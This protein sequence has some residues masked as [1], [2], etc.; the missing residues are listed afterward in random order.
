MAKSRVKPAPEEQ[1][2]GIL[3]NGSA[4]TQKRKPSEQSDTLLSANS[5]VE[6]T[7]SLV[8]PTLNEEEGIGE[9]IERAKTAMRQ[10]GVDGEIIVSDSSTDRTPEIAREKGA[11]VVEPPEQGYGFA[12]KYAFEQ[13]RGEY[14]AMGDADTT[15]D[16]EELPKL[17]DL[18]ANGNAD[19]AM[20]SRLDGEIKPGAMP[21][22]HQYIGNPLLTK[23]LNVFYG[24]GVNDAHSG[25]RVFSRDAYEQMDLKSNGMEFASEMIMDAGAKGLTIEELPITYHERTGEATLE[26]FRDGW[27]HVRFMLIN[28]PGYLFT[29]PGIGL[30]ALGTFIVVSVLADFSIGTVSFGP[31]SMIAGCLLVLVGQQ[32]L[33]LGIF[34]TVAGDPIRK[35]QDPLTNW[36]MNNITLERGVLVGTIGL[37][38]GGSYAGYLL[39]RWIASDFRALPFV[40]EDVIAFTAIILGLQIIFNSFFLS[41]MAGEH[42]E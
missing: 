23:F 38:T 21:K 29:L 40:I 13:T 42:H 19:M 34:S 35:P 16:F 33:N 9:C 8:M 11:I 22:L 25:M 27:R 10:L 39:I 31:H 17:Y 32:I 4:T 6:P 14:I 12:Y 30:L 28:A 2:S 24:A 1:T 5:K 18:V 26:S 37:L 41:S 36:L 15:Y 20:G 7:L 3:G